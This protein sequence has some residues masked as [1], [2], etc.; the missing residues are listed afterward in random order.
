MIEFDPLAYWPA[1]AF[2]GLKHC[3]TCLQRKP[4]PCDVGADALEAAKPVAPPEQSSPEEPPP[5]PG[6]SP[7]TDQPDLWDDRKDLA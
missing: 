2:R 6:L 4:C 3:P 1:S 7:A 5:D